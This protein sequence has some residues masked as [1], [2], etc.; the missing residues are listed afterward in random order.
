MADLVKK[1]GRV[2]AKEHKLPIKV[3]EKLAR[4]HLKMDPNYYLKLA[5]FE[6]QIKKH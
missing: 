5:K 2:E 6:R 1:Y 4:D 3:G